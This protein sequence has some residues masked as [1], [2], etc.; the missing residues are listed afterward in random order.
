[1]TA[2]PNP[3]QGLV[4]IHLNNFAN[5]PEINVVNSLGQKLTIEIKQSGSNERSLD[6]GGH[7]AGLYFLNIK[8]GNNYSSITSVQDVS[9]PQIVL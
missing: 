9:I 7:A 1:M 2:F 5:F 6:L 4:N 3:T 8:D